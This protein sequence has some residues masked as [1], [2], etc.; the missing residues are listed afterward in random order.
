MVGPKKQD[1]CIEVTMF[2]GFC[3]IY[4]KWMSMGPQTLATII[5]HK[6]YIV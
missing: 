1:F 6:Y 4:L 3:L 5:G 2:Q